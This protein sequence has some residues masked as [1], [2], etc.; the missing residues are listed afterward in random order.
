MG[1]KTLKAMRM[2]VPGLM[3]LIALMAVKESDWKSLT[4]R[5]MGIELSQGSFPFYVLPVI[6]GVLY[7]LANLRNVFF[8]K[9]IQQVVGNIYDRLLSPFEQHP[10][11]ASSIAGLR[12]SSAIKHIF[13]RFIDSEP[14]LQEKAN[15]VRMNGL[16]L[17]SLADVA[18]LCL[19]FAPIYLTLYRIKSLVYYLIL[20]IGTL[21]VFTLVRFLLLPLATKKHLK[22]SN[23]QIDSILAN[24]YATLETR[25]LEVVRHG[26]GE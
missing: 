9:P 23:E 24:H 22:Y 7:Y 14:D 5:I 8:R 19:I 11:I 26:I 2:L 17:S 13:Y 6:L 1:I 15:N 3:I 20:F 4:D 21:I 25:V 16:V 12:E 18:I 10:E